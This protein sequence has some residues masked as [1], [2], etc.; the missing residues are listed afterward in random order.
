MSACGRSLWS[1]NRKK[2]FH[3]CHF[4]AKH[5]AWADLVLTKLKPRPTSTEITRIDRNSPT[6]QSKASRAIVGNVS[7]RPGT[8]TRKTSRVQNPAC[9][10]TLTRYQAGH[11]ESYRKLALLEFPV[12][13]LWWLPPFPGNG[14]QSPHT[15]SCLLGNTPPTVT[16]S[17]W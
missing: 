2:K 14:G 5:S 10:H 16:F 11:Q 7:G 4:G 3:L 1:M 9:A 13:A 12:A 6:F 17:L 15:P 8:N